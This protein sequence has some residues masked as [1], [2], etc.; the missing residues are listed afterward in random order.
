[1]KTYKGQSHYPLLT[2]TAALE[3]T[4]RRATAA[5]AADAISLEAYLVSIGVR[6]QTEIDMRAAHAKGVRRATAT[7]WAHI[8][9]DF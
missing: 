2:H 8:F 6:T 5:N 7:E 4:K 3:I 9:S 1:M